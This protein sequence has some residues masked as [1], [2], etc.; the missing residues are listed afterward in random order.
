MATNQND[1]EVYVNGKLKSLVSTADTP[2][3]AKAEDPLVNVKLSSSD[4][5]RVGNFKLCELIDQTNDIHSFYETNKKR[6]AEKILTNE[7]FNRDKT[8]YDFYATQLGSL[9]VGSNSCRSRRGSMDSDFERVEFDFNAFVELAKEKLAQIDEKE[10]VF[11]SVEANVFERKITLKN[12]RSIFKN[13]DFVFSVVS[14]LS[15]PIGND[16]FVNTAV[17]ELTL[18]EFVLA[19]K[20]RFPVPFYAVAF[21][22]FKNLLR[23]FFPFDKFLYKTIRKILEKTPY[24]FKSLGIE[25]NVYLSQVV[26]YDK[27]LLLLRSVFLTAAERCQINEEILSSNDFMVVNTHEV[28]DV[29]IRRIFS[30]AGLLPHPQVTF[31]GL[32]PDILEVNFE[33]EF[34]MAKTTLDLDFT[35]DYEIEIEQMRD[36][37]VYLRFICK[38]RMTETIFPGY[39]LMNTE[40]KVRFG[41]REL[42]RV[43]LEADMREVLKVTLFAGTRIINLISKTE[44]Q[45]MNCTKNSKEY[46]LE[47]KQG[48]SVWTPVF[49]SKD[50][51]VLGFVF[52]VPVLP[53]TAR[54]T[55]LMMAEPLLELVDTPVNP[56]AFE[57]SN[58][59][60]L[61][62]RFDINAFSKNEFEKTQKTVNLIK[63]KPSETVSSG[64]IAKNALES[65]FNKASVSF[66]S[67]GPVRIG[68]FKVSVRGFFKTHLQPTTEIILSRNSEKSSRFDLNQIYEQFCFALIENFPYDNFL[69]SQNEFFKRKRVSIYSIQNLNE[70]EVISIHKKN[71]RASTAVNTRTVC[72]SYGCTVSFDTKENIDKC[73]GHPGTWDFGHTGTNLEEAMKDGHLLW[74][75]H[76]T[77]CGRGW[78]EQCSSFH[79]HEHREN[80]VAIDLEDPFSQKV[81]RKNIRQNWLGKVSALRNDEAQIRW[82]I[83][84]FCVKQGI[85]VLVF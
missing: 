18:Q 6:S 24:F 16:S 28:E 40:A 61:P 19:D 22:T 34:S 80:R 57:M 17:S 71:S 15:P 12:L 42:Q 1:Y 48:C 37:V 70:E 55:S 10:H 50:H 41:C 54:S 76:W 13:Y 20:T 45:Q 4:F 8:F 83:G 46:T 85:K 49:S 35:V 68:E 31:R 2:K 43:V 72:N 36:A 65:M 29:H 25:K 3:V 44:A 7:K 67:F 74:N 47:F 79:F 84:Q 27:A 21:E 9:T 82:K 26:V 39:L 52:G 81:F 30:A 62:V 33:E 78:N 32:F 60:D 14:L 64:H 53:R 23:R 66:N 11:Y 75:A 69:D 73:I 38:D 77:C 58:V 59:L 56:K 5:F 51:S 63:F